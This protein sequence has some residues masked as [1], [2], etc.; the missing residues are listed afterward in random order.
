MSIF[1][2]SFKKFVKKQ[3]EVRQAIISQGNKGDS[4]FSNNKLQFS[5]SAGGEEITIDSHAFYTN[6]I[7]RACVIRMCSGVDLKADSVG[8]LE[9]GRYENV[10]DL[11]GSGLA[12]RYILEGGTLVNVK[13]KT[14]GTTTVQSLRKGFPG[15]S[16]RGWGFTYGD[17]T[18]RGDAKEGYGIVPMPGITDANIRTKSAYG[19]LRE[20]KVNF[21]C[22]NQRQLEILELLY[23]RPGYPIMLEWGWTTYIGN[24]GK[25]TS[26]F[27]HVSEFFNQDVSQELVNLKII[28]NKIKTSGNYDG[29]F[30]MCKN[31]NYKARPDGGFDCTTEIIS[32][33]EII[34]SLKTTKTALPAVKEDGT[35]DYVL[36]DEM[37]VM[38]AKMADLTNV[39]TETTTGGN[40]AIIK[41]TNEQTGEVET[42]APTSCF[43]AGTKITMEDGSYKNIEDISIDD[44]IKSKNGTSKVLKTIIH[45]GE[46]EVYSINNSNYFVTED[47]PFE[48]TEGWKAINSENTFEKHGINA[49]VLKEGDI[50]ITKEGSEKITSIKMGEEKI[51]TVYN[52]S[53][54]NEHVY[55]AN[56]YLVHNKQ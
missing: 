30:G 17:P 8:L 49:N 28:Q 35:M 18:I 54:N 21:K 12:R 36:V 41:K 43:I 26:E 37:A 53:V 6:T 32:M 5:N 1:K 50:L 44:I 42:Q 29:L 51:N 24:D 9:G 11:V 4:R 14:G 22:H 40:T 45:E 48:T 46:F 56:N 55:Y 7:N 20:A 27:P 38:L 47:H 10:K 39:T 19:S 34:E 15:V 33:G 16:S 2:E 13:K 52:L 31:F 3:L 23:M 25:R